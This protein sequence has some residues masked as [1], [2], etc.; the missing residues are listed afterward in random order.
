MKYIA[1]PL[2]ICLLFACGS[3]TTENSANS[4]KRQYTEQKNPVTVI[5][6]QKG[7][8]RKELVNNGKLVALRK[9][10]LQ[11][12]VGEQLEKLSFKNGDH[13][14]AG[15]VIA[16][17]APFTFSQQLGNAEIQLKRNRMDMQNLLIGQ[18]YTTLDTSKIPPKIYEIAFVKSG[19]AEACQ[20][21]KTA[22]FNFESAQLVAP[23]GGVLANIE[24]KRYDRVDAGTTFCTLIDNSEFE[25][26]FRVVESEVGDIRL[27]DE[28][29]L[30]PFS[31]RKICLGRI[32][33][34]NPV[35]DENGM[36]LVKALVKNPGG[37]IDGMN[38][39]VIVE[40]ELL[41]QLVVP[42]SA[43]LLRDNQE[44]LF[45]YTK[46]GVAFWTYIQ[47]LAEN[48]TSYSVIA[49]PDKGATLTPGDTVIVS[50]NLNLA[51]ESKV[52]LK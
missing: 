9:T 49:N 18:G 38:V 40:K 37:L 50:G 27:N 12:R 16:A 43:V 51:H 48:T 26:K 45:K 32:S 17:L 41:D 24:K 4:E 25:V 8:F 1:F 22:K 19:Y 42:K 23:F 33:E 52:E 5:V 13:V 44:V 30:I 3:K 34:I 7:P 15:Q 6:L 46:N 21:F 10:N 14:N 36:I 39:K 11:F 47:T 2:L 28:V 31:S 29:Q 35:V 20:S